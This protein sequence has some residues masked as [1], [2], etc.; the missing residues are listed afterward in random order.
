MSSCQGNNGKDIDWGL[1]TAGVSIDLF[2]LVP[3]HVSVYVP[4][5]ESKTETHIYTTQG[6]MKVK[7]CLGETCIILQ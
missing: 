1:K 2:S 3:Y 5:F 4:T 7:F 6:L